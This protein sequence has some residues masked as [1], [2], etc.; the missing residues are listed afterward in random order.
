MRRFVLYL[1]AGMTAVVCGLLAGFLV[2][3]VLS[4]AT[5]LLDLLALFYLIAA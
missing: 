1:L 3:F 2:M 5:P 4:A